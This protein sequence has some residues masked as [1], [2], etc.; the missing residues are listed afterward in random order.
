MDYYWPPMAH[1]W[2]A[3]SHYWAATSH[4]WAAMNHHWEY[5]VLLGTHDT[6]ARTQIINGLGVRPLGDL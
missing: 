3:M 2:A 5:W 4:Y 1:Y 6:T